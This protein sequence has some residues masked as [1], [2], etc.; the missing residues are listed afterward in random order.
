MTAISVSLAVGLLT[1]GFGMFG[2][3]STAAAG[4]AHVVG[5]QET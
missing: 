4:A 5:L 3:T 2:L 1:F